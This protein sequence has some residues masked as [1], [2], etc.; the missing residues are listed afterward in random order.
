M[1]TITETDMNMARETFTSM[2][3]TMRNAIV[4]G[5][6]VVEDMKASQASLQSELASLQAQV[7]ALKAD[8]E[9]TQETNKRLYAERSDL[10]SRLDSAQA[11]IVS[12]R[13]DN[14][15]VGQ[16]RDLAENRVKALLNQ[17][18]VSHEMID[19][20]TKERDDAIM[21][22]L[23]L[24]EQ[25]KHFKSKLDAVTTALGLPSPTQTQPP[26]PTAEIHDQDHGI[27]D[28]PQDHHSEPEGIAY[29]QEEHIPF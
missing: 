29:S 23:E 24:E 15:N 22:S 17:V 27:G 5:S 9:Y 11:Q 1:T 4:E 18:E 21:R 25:V 8:V 2:F 6:K 7:R 3:D 26:V 14:V 28:I 16:E 10:V 20:L 19:G 13:T 12:L